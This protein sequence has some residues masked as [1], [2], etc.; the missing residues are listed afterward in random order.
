MSALF[1]DQR[2]ATASLPI[3]DAVSV[4]RPTL[5]MRAVGA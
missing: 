3:D 4:R 1:V 5:A 2:L